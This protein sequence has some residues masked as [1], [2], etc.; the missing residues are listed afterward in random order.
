MG[1]MSFATKDRFRLNFLIYRKVGENSSV[2]Y[3]HLG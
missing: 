2:E 1:R 3:S